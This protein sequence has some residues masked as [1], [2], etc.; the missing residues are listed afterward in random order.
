MDQRKLEQIGE[1]LR[2]LGHERRE[3]VEEILS[4]ASQ[5]SP[6][7]AR[8]RYAELDRVSQECIELMQEQ[9]ALVASQLNDGRV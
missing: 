9:R 7:E 6:D 1:R 3:V 2:S 5:G 4:D 8:R